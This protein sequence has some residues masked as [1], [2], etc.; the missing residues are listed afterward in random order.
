MEQ[1]EGEDY[2]DG[3]D[4]DDFIVDDDVDAPPKKQK[5]QQ[6]AA[7][8]PPKTPK[9][10]KQP[11]SST[12]ARFAF[13]AGGNNNSTPRTLKSAGTPSTTTTTT[14]TTTT[15]RPAKKDSREERYPWLV[16]VKDADGLPKTHPDYDPRTLYIPKSAWDRFSPFEKQFWEIKCKLYDTVV[17]FK[18]GK[19]YELYED[20]AT[21]GHQEFDLKLTDR[22]NMRMVGVPESSLDMWVSQFI[23]KG[24]KVARVDQKETALGKELRDKADKGKKGK[25]EKIIRRE[26]TCVLTAGTLVDET[27]LQDDMA[28][29]CMA[30]KEDVI[31]DVTH[32][33]VSFIDTSVGAFYVTQF[34][35][36]AD[37]TK[38][39]T[40]VAQIRPIEVVL[41]KGS[42]GISQKAERIIR[43]NTLPTL[44]KNKVKSDEF[45]TGPLALIDI[46][47]QGYFEDG[48]LPEAIEKSRD[49]DLLMSSLGALFV[50]LRKCQIDREQVTMGNFSV[51]DPIQKASSLVMD[52]KT[53]GNLEIFHN[54]YDGGTDGTLF[55][56]LNRCITPFGKR[57]LKEWVCHPLVDA[58][59]INARLD[60]VEALNA[61]DEF[62]E[63]FSSRLSKL[64]DLERLISRVHA[65]NSKA[66]DFVRIIEGFESIQEAVE[67]IA[68]YGDGG[69]LIGQLLAQLPDMR[70]LLGQ[71]EDAFDRDKAKN[72]GLL[73][74]KEGVET[75]FDESQQVIEGIED[76]L[77]VQL[78]EYQKQFKS[79]DL[80]FVDSGKEIYLVEVPAKLVKSVP[81]S[82]QQMSGT[83]KVKRFYSPEIRKMVRSLQ[84]ARELHNQLALEV[85]KRFYRRF[86]EKYRE[87]RKI[88]QIVAQLDCLLSLAA[89]SR[90]LGEPSCRP[91][92][93]ES[94]RTT[95][96]FEELRHPCMIN[97][98]DFIPNSIYLGGPS[99]NLTL[100][101][102]A[103]A[104]GKS[105]VLR[106][107]CI[108]VLLSQIG[109][110]IPSLS[111]TLTPVDRI[112]SRLGANDNIFASQSTFFVELSE[113]KKILSEATPRSLVILDELG[114]GTSSYDGVAVA[115]AV[116]HHVATHIGCVGY[117]ATHYHSL[118]EEFKTHPEINPMRMRIRVDDESREITF[119]YKLE[120]GVAEG[121]FGMHCAA[122]CGVNRKVIDRAEEAAREFEHTSRLR[123]SLERVRE[124]GGGYVPLGLQSDVAWILRGEVGER[125]LGIVL[126]AVEAL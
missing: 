15:Q 18:K 104:A 12:A 88:I 106:M 45:P 54:S 117:F 85:D 35:D 47:R 58:K 14:T 43:N 21:I 108:G 89:T 39:E 7:P 116:L 30:I 79:K 122:M 101:T 71:W 96:E 67:E 119:L 17:F 16:N 82:W 22:V 49:Q 27:M 100:L 50:Y 112:M 105:T 86:D 76:E 118:A 110:F 109:C 72:E 93:I 48:R 107:T 69:G 52:G 74:P 75:D 125:A 20:D 6:K 113:T 55:K 84:E 91:T 115:Q 44:I 51:Y 13:T 59:R 102:G 11:T 25:E 3:L 121:S 2:M 65:Q 78:R 120:N 53:L 95:I 23:A 36:D 42:T 103:N 124:G 33:G 97:I 9:T 34:E 5:Q 40:L 57:L 123:E 62:R 60:A 19:F 70:E 37:L 46:E 80:K 8:P 1:E 64:P 41:E 28:T 10:P 99:P 24:Y 92:F 56:L 83:Q 94:D 98:D 26:L 114:R 38:F 61:N 87:W 66:V 73:V 4:D 81:S 90:A 126:K 63:T 31:D 68:Q 111:A 32:F 77:K 29:Y